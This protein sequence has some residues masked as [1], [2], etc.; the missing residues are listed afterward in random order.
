MNKVITLNCKI[1]AV[2]FY[3][4]GMS[5]IV[6]ENTYIG[7]KVMNGADFTAAD[8]IPDLKFPRA[9]MYGVFSFSRHAWLRFLA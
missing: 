3:A 4:Q 1:P 7:L 8:I 2:L 9:Q 6:N 5:V